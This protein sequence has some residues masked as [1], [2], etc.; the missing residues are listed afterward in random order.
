MEKVGGSKP[1]MESETKVWK[2]L[3]DLNRSE[4]EANQANGLNMFLLVMDA[5]L[6]YALPDRAKYICASK[7]F[8]D[9]GIPIVEE[10]QLEESQNVAIPYYSRLSFF[11]KFKS[12]L[13]IFQKVGTIVRIK[14]GN[15]KR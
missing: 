15:V 3:K 11:G 2:R 5:S 4:I 1:E 8:D 6:P 13:P 7:I 14:G 9:S 10:T 12:E